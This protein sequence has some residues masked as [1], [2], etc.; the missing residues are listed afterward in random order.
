VYIFVNNNTNFNFLKILSNYTIWDRLSQKTISRYCPFK[1]DVTGS[2]AYFVLSVN[3]V[4]V[5]GRR[6]KLRRL[7]QELE[8]E[9]QGQHQL[10]AQQLD[11]L[12]QTRDHFAHMKKLSLVSHSL[13]IV[14][15]RI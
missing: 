11:T 3:V 1:A 8:Q 15:F 14:N 12:K 9:L 6:E 4:Q 10:L 2:F 7:E 5:E 13:A